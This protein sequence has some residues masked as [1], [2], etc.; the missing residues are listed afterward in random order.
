MPMLHL[1]ALVE[2]QKQP[3]GLC[4]LIP[5]WY[6]LQLWSIPL[7]ARYGAKLDH[8]MQVMARSETGK[9]LVLSM[10]DLGP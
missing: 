4:R 3:I 9:S 6:G 5:G 7:L 8:L 1:L 10:M 2:R